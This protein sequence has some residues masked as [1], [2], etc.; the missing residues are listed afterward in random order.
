MNLTEIGKRYQTDK[1]SDD[2]RF[3]DFYHKFFGPIRQQVTGLCEFGI[4]Y[5]SSLRMW[6]EYFPNA[7]IVGFDVRPELLFEEPRIKTY[8]AGQH[9]V[10]LIESYLGDRTFDIVIDDA[11]HIMSYQIATFKHAWKYV[12]PGGFYVI[13]DLHTSLMEEYIDSEITAL[14][15]LRDID[16]AEYDIEFLDIFS[17][18]DI[19]NNIDCITSIIRKNER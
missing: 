3:T 1:A 6:Q 8:L 18:R 5:G 13:E 15:F 16:Y 14:E 2:H 12:R 17:N 4:A 7:N 9:E 10:D 19:K 11:C